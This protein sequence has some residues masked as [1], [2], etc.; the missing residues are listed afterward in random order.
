MRQAMKH[1]RVET[2]IGQGNLN[3]GPGCRIAR[4]NAVEFVLNYLE[5]RHCPFI[6]ESRAQRHG[7]ITACQPVQ[8]PSAPQHSALMDIG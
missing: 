6:L 2:R 7:M 8:I 5:H 4:D 1:H 3:T